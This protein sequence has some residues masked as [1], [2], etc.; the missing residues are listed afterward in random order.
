MLG[1]GQ[2]ADLPTAITESW[3]NGYDADADTLTAEIYLKGFNGLSRPYFIISDDGKG[4]SQNEIL[5][6]WLGLGT[7]SKARA[8]LE[9]RETEAALWKKP[10]KKAG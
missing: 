4:M 1:K 2:I 10:G 8:R 7:D 3:K 5:E 9:E 6:K